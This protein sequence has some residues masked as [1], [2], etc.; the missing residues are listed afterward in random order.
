M[1]NKVFSNLHTDYKKALDIVLS[2]AKGNVLQEE[3]TDGD[4]LLIHY[5][6]EQ[7]EAIELVGRVGDEA[8]LC[9]TQV[10]DFWFG[11]RTRDPLEDLRT[12]N[13]IGADAYK[14]CRRWEKEDDQA[15][16][17]EREDDQAT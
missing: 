2:L 7:L 8:V 17:W 12:W 11:I 5:R 14:I 4:D 9:L 6:N 15:P 10:A 13:T 3:D 16:W 1:N